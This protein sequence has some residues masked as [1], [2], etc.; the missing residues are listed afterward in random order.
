MKKQT[1]GNDERSVEVIVQ[2]GVRTEIWRNREGNV[3][4][5]VK[6]AKAEEDARTKG[7]MGNEQKRPA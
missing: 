4:E 6:Y 5:I 7:P 2:N 1:S 3:V